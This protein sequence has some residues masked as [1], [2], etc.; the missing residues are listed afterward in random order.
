[1]IEE[2][3]GINIVEFQVRVSLTFLRRLLTKEISASL[4][5]GGRTHSGSTRIRRADDGYCNAVQ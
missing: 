4:S 5:I 2:H 1:M 3:F